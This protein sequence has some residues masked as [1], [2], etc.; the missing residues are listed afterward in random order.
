MEIINVWHPEDA[1][2][3]SRGLIVNMIYWHEKSVLDSC[4]QSLLGLHV[5]HV[6]ENLT[7]VCGTLEHSNDAVYD[8]KVCLILCPCRLTMSAKALR[9]QTVRPPRL[10]VRPFVRSSVQIW[11]PRYLMNGMSNLDDTYR[12]YSLAPTD[13]LIGFWRLNVKV[14]VGRRGGRGIDVDAGALKSTF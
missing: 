2:V 8:I 9:L 5:A 3:S 10:S 13:D 4:Y 1:D 11:L 12:D 6:S 14:T 7:F